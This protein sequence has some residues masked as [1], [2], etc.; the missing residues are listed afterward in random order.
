ML[1]SQPPAR[2]DPDVLIRTRGLLTPVRSPSRLLF[3]FAYSFAMT[4]DMAASSAAHAAAA[5]GTYFQQRSASLSPDEPHGVMPPHDGDERY[6]QV[7][8]SQR[9][10]VRPSQHRPHQ[11]SPQGDCLEATETAQ[12]RQ[13]T[14][15]AADDAF[16]KQESQQEPDATSPQITMRQQSF[17]YASVVPGARNPANTLEYQQCTY[18][19]AEGGGYGRSSGEEHPVASRHYDDKAH[20]DSDP[21]PAVSVA[22]AAAAA[23][24]TAVGRYRSAPVATDYMSAYM[25]MPRCGILTEWSRRSES[26]HPDGPPSAETVMPF[27]GIMGEQYEMSRRAA[28][29]RAE[30]AADP[31]FSAMVPELPPLDQ[32]VI[33]SLAN[34]ITGQ[35]SGDP[36]PRLHAALM[37]R[38]GAWPV[39]HRQ[40]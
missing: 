28:M 7:E 33:P 15:T 2:V 18:T 17:H 10:L 5:V 39:H 11:Y 6:W 16:V 24:A 30:A 38:R 29:M 14:V 20:F 3:S 19:A 27:Y 9:R 21:A 4:E 25:A 35:H 23:A 22:A 34:S 1:S 40:Q 31:M 8:E 32:I 13:R 36:A 26:I 37:C 12:K